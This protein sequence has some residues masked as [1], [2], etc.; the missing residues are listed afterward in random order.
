MGILTALTSIDGRPR[1]S[2][3]VYSQSA[4]QSPLSPAAPVS[5]NPLALVKLLPLMEITRGRA[6]TI[7]ALID[8]PVATG[9]PDLS[10]ANIREVP[11]SVG[12]R[13][14]RTRSVACMHGTFVAGILVAARESP[15]PAICPD[16]TLAARFRLCAPV[17]KRRALLLLRQER[18]VSDSCNVSTRKRAQ[19]LLTETVR[20]IVDGPSIPIKTGELN[21]NSSV[22]E[23]SIIDQS[24]FVEVPLRFRFIGRVKRRRQKVIHKSLTEQRV[25]LTGQGSSTR[26]TCGSEVLGLCGSRRLARFQLSKG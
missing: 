23:I 7:V 12:A 26:L 20:L 4:P 18:I 17:A 24:K 1:A 14:D 22:R 2:N 5:T 8:G 13:C 19:T 15:A 11:G 3:G 10:T 9:H 25:R 21:R 6:A 16:C